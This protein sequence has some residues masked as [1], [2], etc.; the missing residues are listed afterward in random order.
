MRQSPRNWRW[1]WFIRSPAIWAEAGFLLPDLANE[2]NITIDFREKAPAAATRN[3]YLDANNNVSAGKSENGT[4]ASGVPGSVA[5][6]F[7]Y[8]KYAR[9][10]FRKLIQPAIDLADKGFAITGGRSR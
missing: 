7:S 6:I 8:L 1:P 3:M 10:P 9:L 5:G 4:S 2:K